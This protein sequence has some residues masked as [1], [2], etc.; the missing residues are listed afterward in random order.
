MCLTRYPP[1]ASAL[2]LPAS[3]PRSRSWESR[4]RRE[5]AA[6]RLNTAAPLATPKIA[7]RAAT[8]TK[9]DA[10]LGPTTQAP[11][12]PEPAAPSSSAGIRMTARTRLARLDT[13]RRC[14][15]ARTRMTLAMWVLRDRV[16][17]WLTSS[18]HPVGFGGNAGGCVEYGL[19]VQA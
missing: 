6:G 19:D 16:V 12:S 7:V 1:R 11:A 18:W 14:I 17:S 4:A 8:K 5:M 15:S 10:T 2:T 13:T 9:T 3:S